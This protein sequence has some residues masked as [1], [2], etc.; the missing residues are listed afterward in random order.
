MNIGIV[1][2]WFD[3]GAAYVSKAYMDVLSK[4]QNVYIYARGGEKDSK[5][6]PRWDLPNVTYGEKYK[7][8]GTRYQLFTKYKRDYVDMLHFEAWLSGNG[9][10]LV[11]FN[12]EH[13]VSLFNRTK[14]L[15]YTIGAYI[16]YYKKDTVKQFRRYD[17]LLC[18]TKRHYSVFRN[19]PNTFYYPWGTDINIF[20]P[21][22]NNVCISDEG[23]ISFFHSAG[24]GGVNNRK[25]TDLLL[26]AFHK[27]T[28]DCKLILH[29]Q[30]P[31]S[32]YG[33]EVVDIIRRDARIQF[34]KK[35]VSAPGLY[36]LGD[37]FVYPSRLD[38]IG[39]CV[40]EALAC[41]LPVITTDNAPMNEFVKDGVNGLL[42]SVKETRMRED[43]YYWP[44][45]IA[46]IDDLARKMQVYVDDR[47]VLAIHKRQCREFAET[48][49]NWMKNASELSHD[50]H[51]LLKKSK[52][53]HSRPRLSERTIWMSEEKYVA[54]LSSFRYAV[55]KA[56]LKP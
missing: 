10:D 54:L 32:K 43:S 34:I 48:R 44:E 27:V 52:M 37:V 31:V 11:I 56:L 46:C 45:K 29:S 33:N 12:E 8:I 53:R 39:L 22:P 1:T 40:P 26:K 35:T 42:V 5:G 55:R 25:G 9:I 20:K 51:G 47:D 28:G 19:F 17:F 38:G 23:A 6:D 2:T 30:V 41:G 24:Y 14:R 13:N 7:P 4:D 21:K 16:D 49:L 15:G 3:R 50:L 36:H 18:N